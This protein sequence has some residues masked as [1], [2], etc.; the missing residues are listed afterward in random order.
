MGVSA[1]DAPPAK[2]IGKP[3]GFGALDQRLQA[4][5]VIAVQ[6]LGRAE[7]HG[8]AML[9]H[10][11]TLENPVQRSEW[12]SAINHEVLRDDLEPVHHRRPLE[13]MLV[14]RNAK[15]DADAVF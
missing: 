13:N 5:Q 8:D 10:T 2:M 14:M 12:A 15:A 6:T 7:I 3:R 9:D 4:L 1:I 11:V